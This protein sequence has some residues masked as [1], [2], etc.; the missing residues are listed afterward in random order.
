MAWSNAGPIV[1]LE[2]GET[3]HWEYSWGEKD[4]RGVQFAHAHTRGF[5]S[6]T[7]LGIAIA[8]DQGKYVVGLQQATYWVSIRNADPR[9]SLRH[10]LAGGGL[11]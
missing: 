7:H 10:N 4:D 11:T 3:A 9:Y 5:A 6:P 1:T 2:P 8:F